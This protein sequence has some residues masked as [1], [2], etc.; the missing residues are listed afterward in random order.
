MWPREGSEA[1]TV[2][3]LTEGNGLHEYFMDY[4]CIFPHIHNLF[5]LQ[6]VAGQTVWFNV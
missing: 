6:N 5:A 1:D 3:Y 2:L 4:G